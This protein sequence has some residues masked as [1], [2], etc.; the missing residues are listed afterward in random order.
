LHTEF[1]IF[2]HYKI[3]TTSHCVNHVYTLPPKLSSV[4]KKGS[5]SIFCIY[6]SVASI[7]IGNDEYENDKYEKTHTKISDSVCK[8]LK[9]DLL[10]KNSQNKVLNVKTACHNVSAKEA[11]QAFNFGMHWR[12]WKSP[13]TSSI[14]AAEDTVVKFHCL[15]KY[16]GKNH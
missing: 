10:C 5:G 2:A 13:Y 16:P 7:L 3:N 11:F 1:R 14:W 12:T 4:I 8:D 6:A 9:G 15:R